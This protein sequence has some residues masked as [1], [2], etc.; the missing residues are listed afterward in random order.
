MRS[1]INHFA[2]GLRRVWPVVIPIALFAA[3]GC[4][5]SAPEDVFVNEDTTEAIVFVKTDAEE[6]LNRSWAA[7]NLY[8]LS[9]I[10]C[11]APSSFRSVG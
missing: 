1:H 3:P 11:R 6:T 7:S 9:P 10:S 8:K 4:K 2:G 5:E